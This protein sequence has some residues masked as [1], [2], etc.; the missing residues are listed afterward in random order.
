M[1]MTDRIHTLTVALDRDI[2]DDDI[3]HVLTAIQMVRGVAAVTDQHVS[4]MG[5]WSARQ[6]IRSELGQTMLDVFLAISEGRKITVE[7]RKER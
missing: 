1:G 2:R 7:P 3:E 4:N 6:R 5:D